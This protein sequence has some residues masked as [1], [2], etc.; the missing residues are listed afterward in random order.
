MS[1]GGGSYVKAHQHST[2]ARGC[3]LQAVGKSRAGNTT[4]IHLAVYSYGLPIEFTVR[5]SDIHDR[6]EASE[7]IDLLPPSTAIR[8]ANKLRV[9][10]PEL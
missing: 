6:T 2:G 8:F 3:E 9:K 5:G 7:L 1:V 4:K 10:M